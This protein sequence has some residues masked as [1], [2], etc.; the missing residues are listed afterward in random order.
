MTKQEANELIVKDVLNAQPD[1]VVMDEL[2]EVYPSFFVFFYQS[3]KYISS[4][5]LKD[6]RVGQ[7]PVIV[8]KNTSK[9]FETSAAKS[10][11]EYIKCFEACG[12]PLAELTDIIKIIAWVEGAEKVKATKLIKRYGNLGLADAKF[13]VDNVLEGNSSAFQ[14]VD[15]QEIDQTVT[16]LVNLGFT[17][18]R[19][20]SNQC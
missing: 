6:M 4:G 15:I 19:L 5:K 20:W 3:K 8:C 11:L 10:P 12:D 9:V 18:K 14:V 16:D 7:G 2:T 13:I 1:C 17:A